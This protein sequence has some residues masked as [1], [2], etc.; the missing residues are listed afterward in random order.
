MSTQ[1]D[2]SA[3]MAD[4]WKTAALRPV[5]RLLGFTG[6]LWFIGLAYKN[7]R[8]KTRTTFGD[9]CD[10]TIEF[11]KTFGCPER[12]KTSRCTGVSSVGKQRRLGSKI[13]SL[14]DEPSR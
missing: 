14:P 11:T 3:A 4:P 10:A 13:P 2:I 7:L 12:L 9:N 5:R 6:S 1:P 8:G